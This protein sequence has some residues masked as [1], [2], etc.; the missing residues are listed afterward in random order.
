MGE[1]YDNLLCHIFDDVISKPP[2]QSSDLTIDMTG[3][4]PYNILGKIT[5]N[6][7]NLLNMAHRLQFCV[8]QFHHKN[9]LY[10]G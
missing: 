10:I 5:I 1:I 6:K 8:D 7:I 2:I 4:N 9:L 3:K